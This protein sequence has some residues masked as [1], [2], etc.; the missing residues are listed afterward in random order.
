M[1]YLCWFIRISCHINFYKTTATFTFTKSFKTTC[2]CSK[3]LE[4][5]FIDAFYFLSHIHTQQAITF[6]RLLGG[7]TIDI[8]ISPTTLLQKGAAGKIMRPK[9]FKLFVPIMGGNS[10]I[11]LYIGCLFN[12]TLHKVPICPFWT[13][14]KF[15]SERL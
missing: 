14:L 10:Y 8:F 5:W 11:I 7:R 3:V 1:L 12:V 15:E 9:Y 2:I 13:F 4:I 6:P